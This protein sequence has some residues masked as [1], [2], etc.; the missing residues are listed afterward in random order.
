MK[1][2]IYYLELKK[3]CPYPYG[4]YPEDSEYCGAIFRDE[5]LIPVLERCKES[6]IL[7]DMSGVSLMPGAS[8][9]HEVFFKLDPKYQAMISNKMMV[10]G[11]ILQAEIIQNY[12]GLELRK[13]NDYNDFIRPVYV[14]STRR[15]FNR[16]FHRS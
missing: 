16:I 10:K 1:T 6:D 11:M 12:L 3:N 4:R 9:F 2:K 13:Q 7:F 15:F 5:V 8:W 14:S